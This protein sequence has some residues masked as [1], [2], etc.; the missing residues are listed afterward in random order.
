M[1]TEFGGVLAVPLILAMVEVAKRVGLDTVWAAPVAVVMGMV[2]AVGWE[3]GTVY[4]EAQRW[5]QAALWGMAL[6]LSA[7]GLYSGAK[8]LGEG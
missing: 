2:L 7:S 8:K 4:P 3:A 1:P 5:I 6:G